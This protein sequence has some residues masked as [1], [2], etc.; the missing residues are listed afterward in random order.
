M[1]Y[2]IEIA[3]TEDV[4]DS[5]AFL[6]LVEDYIAPLIDAGMITNSSAITVYSNIGLRIADRLT[7]LGPYCGRKVPLFW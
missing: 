4:E 3:D 2:K 1:R 7:T 5:K 6:E